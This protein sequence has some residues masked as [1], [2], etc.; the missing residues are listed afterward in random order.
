[1]EKYHNPL[2]CLEK[3]SITNLP[4]L[5][6]FIFPEGFELLPNTSE[7]FELEF[8]FCEYKFLAKD[9]IIQRGAFF[10]S[11][12]GIPTHHYLICSN[13]SPLIWEGR[14]E[15]T[16]AYFREGNFSTG[17]ATHGLFPYR[18]KF[19]PQLI[20]GILNILRIQEGDV[21]LDPMCGSG[22]LNIEASLIGIDSIGIEKSP[23]C[24]I[25][26]KVKH[27]ALKVH[28]S[29]IEEILKNG[30]KNYQ[31]L[32]SSTIL[33]ESF[34]TYENPSNLITLL[35][36]LDAMG[37]ARR[38][39]K[40]ID[41]LFPAVLKRYA[42]QINSFI[43]ARDKL[44]LRVGNARFEQG[45]AKNLPINDN[46]ID[47]IITSPPYSFAIDYAE[48]DKPQLE[49]LGYNVDELREDM[50]GLKGRTRKE[51]LARYF[52]DMEKVLSEMYRVLKPDKYA[53]III[54]SNDIQTGG[55]RLE[56]KIEEMATHIGFALDQKIVKPI[57]GIQNT[58][59]DEYILFFRRVKYAKT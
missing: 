49:Y 20:K 29:I 9:E 2:F 19:H 31:K 16:K 33:P 56:T 45:D 6:S 53:V 59:K 5:S 15:I 35:A 8:A 14:S 48:N 40:S 32:V 3:S 55:I 38:C 21:V 46:S 10:K 51:K 43:Q 12:E 50:I 28:I 42:G 27:E 37:Y 7:I 18:G 41:V 4:K 47:A 25:M 11:V 30:L 26:S 23:F 34:L 1:M 58:M 39:T 13:N 57:K 44:N 52:E 17:Y 24:I 36:F 22:T 54:G